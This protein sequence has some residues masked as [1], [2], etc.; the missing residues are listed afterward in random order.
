MLCLVTE[1]GS[2]GRDVPMAVRCPQPA[3]SLQAVI[4]ECVRG[5]A[6]ERMQSRERSVDAIVGAEVGLRAWQEG[7][8]AIARQ[9][10][11]SG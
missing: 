5:R 11:G 4:K 10:S 1:R 3:N 6:K 2:D 9:E 7:G 8:S